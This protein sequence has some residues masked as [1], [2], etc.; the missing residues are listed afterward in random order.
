[1]PELSV[2]EV[3]LPELHLPELTREGIVRALSEVHV[4]EVELPTAEGV[5]VRSRRLDLSRIDL[6]RA[7]GG[8]ALF[9]RLARPIV[10]RP[11]WPVAIGVVV[12]VA[13]VGVVLSRQPAIRDGAD[14]A[15]RRARE[16]VDA[17]RAQ[18]AAATSESPTDKVA[19]DPVASDVAEVMTSVEDAAA[20]VSAPA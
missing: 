12:A 4:P 1:M 18:M 6:G 15:A 14:R 20:A 2:K 13:V 19:I 17:M 3:R 11:R 9:A 16:R 7:L 8:A 10:R 5:T